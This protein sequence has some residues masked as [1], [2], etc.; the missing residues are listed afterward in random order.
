MGP[1]DALDPIERSQE[2][3]FGLIMVLTFT[4]ALSTAEAGR[5]E[6]RQMTIGVIG[7]NIAWGL[8]DAAM[9][10]MTTFARRAR[11]V[12]VV[13]RLRNAPQADVL[14]DVL[15]A[16]LPL[17]FASLLT[18]TDIETLRGR[19][20]LATAT[21]P[22]PR[23]DGGDLRRAAHVFALVFACT[24][25]AVIPF[26]IV[27]DARLAIRIAHALVIGMLFVAGWSLGAH[28]GRP[29]WRTGLV[30]AVGGLALAVITIALGG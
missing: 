12:I 10:L 2:V 18:E 29:P 13:T 11:D 27:S 26:L 9:H 4:G 15:V 25:P 28:A 30:M 16:Y 20:P 6:I 24:V 3:L 5:A 19:L 1:D 17:S 8:V 23:L 7:C 21:R 22:R 14:R